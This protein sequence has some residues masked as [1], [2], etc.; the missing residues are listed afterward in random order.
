MTTL[1]PL[2]IR[3]SEALSS[4]I[5]PGR[6]W[7][8][9]PKLTHQK[10]STLWREVV[11]SFSEQSAAFPADISAPDMALAQAVAAELRAPE[12]PVFEATP[13]GI[14]KESVRLRAA[15]PLRNPYRRQVSM[16]GVR[17][18]VALWVRELGAA[19]ALE[20]LIGAWGWQR[21]ADRLEWRLVRPNTYA[22][23]IQQPWLRPATGADRLSFSGAAGA[24]L[25]D[26]ADGAALLELRRWLAVADEAALGAARAVAAAR[27]PLEE[28]RGRM[29]LAFCFP[30]EEGWAADV[31]EGLRAALPARQPIHQPLQQMFHQLSRD[32]LLA[33]PHPGLLGCPANAARI[34]QVASD[35]RS[36]GLSWVPVL[37]HLEG[38]Q[39]AGLLVDLLEQ[40][41]GRGEEA[42][43]TL[44]ADWLRERPKEALPALV[45]V[46]RQHC[47][48]LRRRILTEHPELA[49]G[50]QLAPE[51][52]WPRPLQRE[53]AGS[54]PLNWQGAGYGELRL[55]DGRSLPLAAINRLGRMLA[56]PRM[57]A[58]TLAAVGQSLDP[59]SRRE[60]CCKM[61]LHH[62]PQKEGGFVYLSVLT[63]CGD[64][65]L[66]WY[67]ETLQDWWSHG[68]S[69]RAV[70]MIAALGA[71]GTLG[72][73]RRLQRLSLKGKAEKVR[74]HAGAVLEE[75]ARAQ[76]L[77]REQ[78]ADRL[79]P[80]SGLGADG[81]RRLD[82]GPR[83]FY[84]AFDDQLVPQLYDESGR[85]LAALPKP[86][87]ADNAVMAEAAQ[88]AWKRMKKEGRAVLS[89]Q[90]ARLEQA[91]IRQRSWG[92][93]EFRDVLLGNPM[94]RL[95]ARRL[96]WQRGDVHAGAGRDATGGTRFRVDETGQPVTLQ[97]E[98]MEWP[99]GEA[100]R[101]TL[102]HPL[103]IPAPERAAWG[104]IFADY[105]IL[106]PFPQLGREVFGLWD[107]DRILQSIP[108]REVTDGWI[109]GLI[110]SGW[111][112]GGVGDAGL[113]SSVRWTEGGINATLEHSG[114]PVAFMDW[115]GKPPT[116][117]RS[118]TVTGGGTDP[119]NRIALSELLRRFY[120]AA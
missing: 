85:L 81:R 38:P 89:E 83:R 74:A 53:I 59:Q 97:D 64:D 46:G 16:A 69:A 22:P 31:A 47:L 20:A 13:A 36:A 6:G 7:G 63:F 95:I 29:A 2:T 62:G 28:L 94:L 32:P 23:M 3:P 120:S 61:V 99:P 27:W 24:D 91:M 15:E 92:A 66:P 82:Y 41:A 44:A 49:G 98:P 55:K 84:A 110:S 25:A 68:G 43:A 103:E 1:L 58:S 88:V 112:R 101:V 87:P 52:D 118:L 37:C 105:A 117:L 9:P 21:G 8:R 42:E 48:D 93:Q 100:P 80:E 96:L 51:S 67:D 45:R 26:R 115:P 34:V 77:D 56:V 109:R 18:L 40:Y 107:R 39:V 104:Q 65:L 57:H 14:L 30:D 76:D 86:G 54:L 111:H 119:V 78:L 50:G 10:P 73:M 70:K 116:T 114:V 35:T 17:A 72:A 90:C 75:A 19:A 12:P 4:A 79:V 106:Q 5:C 33:G 71:C 11:E 113:F 60:F 102:P 108:G